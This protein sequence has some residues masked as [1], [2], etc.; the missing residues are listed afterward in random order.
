MAETQSQDSHEATPPLIGEIVSVRG[1]TAR[2][3]I[4]R[5]SSA[6]GRAATQQA[7]LGNLLRLETTQSVILGLVSELDQPIPSSETAGASVQVVN[8]ELIGERSRG[9]GD[10]LGAFRRGVSSH[11]VLGDKVYRATRDDLVATYSGSGELKVKVGSIIQNKKIPAFVQVDELLGKH[12]AVMGASGTGK[13]CA[14][15]ML[16]KEVLEKRPAAH[17]V[18]IDP[19][20]EY[21]SC[22]E[23]VAE[24]FTSKT[25][26][27]P[28]WL[29]TF[30]EFNEII[31]GEERNES[32]IEILREL[33]PMAKRSFALN[34]NRASSVLRNANLG[35]QTAFS[36][37]TPVP[38]RISDLEIALNECMGKLDL[39][40]DILPFK[41]LK[42]RLESITR[43]PRYSFMFGS[44]TVRDTMADVLGRL[45]RVPTHSKPL[46]IIGLAGLPS[47]VVNVVVSVI[48]RLVFDFAVWSEGKAP[49]TLICE[50][51]HHYAP[52]DSSLGFEPA[53]RALSR[54]AKEGRKYGVSLG[55]VSQRP[56]ELA[57][58]I[59]SQC[60]TI[61]ALRLTN[62]LDQKIVRAGIADAANSLIEFLPSL[63][64]REA[65]VFGDGVPLPLRMRFDDL[66]AEQMPR[67]RTAKFS[68]V[69]RQEIGDARFLQDVIN[70]WRAQ[71]MDQPAAGPAATAAEPTKQVR[72]MRK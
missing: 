25:L 58:N 7:Q 27:L 59:L 55:V 24:T 29:L 52:I 47:E 26:D 45:F 41:R 63:G 53:K 36:V 6:N 21:A 15:A 48:S 68:Q 66:P 1:A 32:E 23:D 42:A 51:A 56:S 14:V 35:D 37:D 60:N 44:V 38:Y 31:L 2:A 8:L 40:K 72:R 16:L 64:T 10:T 61:F 9:P 67:S 3:L 30:E 13:S 28:F 33:I 20:N 49:I 4:S 54:I 65:I 57:S 50:E 17:M 71:D 46:A 5:G 69:W 39:Q 19:H 12:F 62:E 43:D 34:T 70:K 22:F 18:V 11:P